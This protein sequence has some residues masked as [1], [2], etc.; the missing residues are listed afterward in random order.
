MKIQ[1][2]I[3]VTDFGTGAESAAKPVRTFQYPVSLLLALVTVDDHSRPTGPPHASSQLV[4]A[5]LCLRKD[6][7]LVLFLG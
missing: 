4:S 7:C 1:G 2:C 3:I 6:Y 5:P